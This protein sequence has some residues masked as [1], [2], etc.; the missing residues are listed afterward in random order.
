MDTQISLFIA[1]LKK[2]G[3][4]TSKARLAV[5]KALLHQEPLT[6]A[7]LVAKLHGIV[8]RA[9]VYRNIELFESI[10]IVQR[11]Q[12]GWKYKM[13]LSDKFHDHHHHMSCRICG[14][15]FSIEG[16]S[17]IEQDIASI[18]QDQGFIIETHQL[19]IQ[20]ICSTCQRIVV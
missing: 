14:A 11:L 18:A 17:R 19:E 20:G 7:E 12:I 3:S 13:E 2:H 8:D 10:G 15:L 5:F 1:T 4:S 6:M 9:S 16:N